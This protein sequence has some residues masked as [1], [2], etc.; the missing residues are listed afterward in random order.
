M[1]SS[2]EDGTFDAKAMDTEADEAH[3]ASGPYSR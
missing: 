3:H 2:G 1:S